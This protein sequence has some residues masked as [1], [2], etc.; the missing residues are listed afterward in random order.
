MLKKNTLLF[1]F[2]SL[3]FYANAQLMNYYWGHNFN[4]TSSLLGGA[5]IAGEA[6]NTAI[7]YNPA[8]VSEM[9]K[10]NNLSFSANLFTWNF[11]DFKNALGDGIDLNTDNFLVQPQF[12]S[13]TY[14]PSRKGIS[15]SLSVL[16]RIKEQMEINYNHSKYYDVL[17]RL[18]GNEKYNT[19]FVYRNDYSDTWI[20][21]AISHELSD[22]FSYGLS[23]FVSVSSLR[24]NF[25]YSAS[26][27][28][29]NDT[30]NGGSY[31]TTAESEYREFIKFTD[32]R[33]ILKLGLAYDGGNWRVG[34]T[35]TSPSMRAFSTGKQVERIQSQTGI[36][37]GNVPAGLSDFVIFDGQEDKKIS[38]N[39][40]MPFS[41]GAGFIYDFK[42][43]GQKLYF[44]LEFFGKLK[45]Y[46]M[47][48]AEINPDITSPIVYDTLS[49][50][51][52]SSYTYAARSVLNA[53]VGYSWT[54]SNDL[55]F[56]NAFRTDFSA[57]NFI[58]LGNKNYYNYVKTTKYNVY[59]YSGGVEFSFKKNRIIAGADIAF[60]YQKNLA[61]IANFTSPVEYDASTGRALQGT[62]ENNMQMYYVGL[63]IF[64]AATLN[65][66]K[67][68]PDQK[69]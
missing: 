53:A 2:L 39:Y 43:R 59:H 41:T 42:R 54:L 19:T 64:L 61:Q 15:I 26:A 49:N 6:D 25:G 51:D 23:V 69:K 3:A 20:G 11:Y 12:V 1:C 13:Y 50:K 31:S 29:W 56:M 60:G 36:A 37:R 8:T 14:K 38:T 68:N 16:T 5:V 27:T 40:K 24:Y 66:T 17:T 18:P 44:S 57:I 65:F 63:N 9:Q 33:L 46:K 67:K 48:N 28:N 30:T 4:S 35:L 52:W 7:F 32:Y 22:R 58:N 47:V 21:G 55:V 62:P 34:F 45:E 10:G